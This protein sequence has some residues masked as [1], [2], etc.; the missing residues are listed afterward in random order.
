MAPL[1]GMQS[2]NE[3]MVTVVTPSSSVQPWLAVTGSVLIAQRELRAMM[4]WVPTAGKK[5]ARRCSLMLYLA[6]ARCTP[7]AEYPEAV[8]YLAWHPEL[9][10][11]V[12]YLLSGIAAD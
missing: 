11:H 8:L 1:P 2:L 10:T 5:L 4:C 6:A 7:S 9:P 3:R 12:E